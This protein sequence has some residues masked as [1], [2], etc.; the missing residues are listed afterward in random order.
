MTE[1]LKEI[2]ELLRIIC[3][4]AYFNQTEG[5]VGEFDCAECKHYKICC[6]NLKA[7]RLI[8]ELK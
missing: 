1:Q 5:C 3:I 7:K 8:G 4:E 2:L 6:A